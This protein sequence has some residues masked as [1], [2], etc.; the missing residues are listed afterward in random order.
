MLYLFYEGDTPLGF[1][2]FYPS[3]AV[4][5]TSVQGGMLGFFRSVIKSET[6]NVPLGDGYDEY[7]ADPS[8]DPYGYKTVIAPAE[9]SSGFT[10]QR[11]QYV[12]V[13]DSYI[14]T[15]LLL[16]DDGDRGYGTMF[17]HQF[18]TETG[19]ADNK[20]YHGWRTGNLIGP[21]TIAGSGKITAWFRDGLYGTDVH[22]GYDP[23]DV[24]D[25][26]LVPGDNLYVGI[27]ATSEHVACFDADA[28]NQTYQAYFVSFLGDPSLV[29]TS[30]P[31]YTGADTAKPIMLF[32]WQQYPA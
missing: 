2:D 30:F 15:K 14:T 21:N 24:S 18:G 13:A 17:G 10:D 9:D 32:M 7:G 20:Y 26:S 12:T 25:G 23:L 5:A 29:S 19:A 4:P 6:A 11:S 16:L 28:N 31:N 22:Y 8:V 1:F 3:V 27:D